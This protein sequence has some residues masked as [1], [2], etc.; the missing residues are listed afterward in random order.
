MAALHVPALSHPSCGNQNSSFICVRSIG[1]E[2]GIIPHQ[3]HGLQ[4]HFQ[5]P[6]LILSAYFLS[7]CFCTF[8]VSVI[9]CLIGF[10]C[11]PLPV[12][13]AP[14]PQSVFPLCS[15]D[16][17]VPSPTSLWFGLLELTLIWPWTCFPAS[18][19]CKFMSWFILWLLTPGSGLSLSFPSWFWLCFCPVLISLSGSR[20]FLLHC[21]PSPTPIW[22]L[23]FDSFRIL[24]TFTSI[25]LLFSFA[26]LLPS[27][28]FPLS[29]S[30]ITWRRPT[31]VIL[32]PDT[33][34]TSPWTTLVSGSSLSG[35]SLPSTYLT[36]Q[37]HSEPVVVPGLIACL[38]CGFC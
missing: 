33:L 13:A 36:Y 22:M 14:L 28:V 11:A 25:Y 21:G 34:S 3:C 19:P 29:C 5:F 18:V 30:H 8:P 38:F 37:K 2:C 27:S 26:N 24:S 16:A 7:W 23:N 12:S 9:S 1:W 6:A 32:I 17:L 15:D 35:P 31:L 10:T 4:L 20:L